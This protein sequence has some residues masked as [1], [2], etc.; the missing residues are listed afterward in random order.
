MINFFTRIFDLKR[1]KKRLYRLEK[2]VNVPTAFRA[3]T[4]RM[5]TNPHHIIITIPWMKKNPPK[6]LI[7]IPGGCLNCIENKKI[8]DET[9][10]FV[11]KTRR[12][13]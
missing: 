8:I 12:L 6:I 3:K 11:H 2:G 9:L 5:A 7:V 10:K 1:K 13:D 4:C